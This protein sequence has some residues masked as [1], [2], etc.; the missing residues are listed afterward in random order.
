MSLLIG[1]VITATDPVL[2]ATI[3]VGPL[4]ERCIPARLR[5]TLSAESG[6]ND[7][8]AMMLVMV[9]VYLTTLPSHQVASAWFRHTLLWQILVAIGIGAVIGLVAGLGVRW[10]RR[11]AYQGELSLLTV[12]LSLTFTTLILT[13][14]VGGDGI[15]GTFVAAAVFNRFLPKDNVLEEHRLQ[16]ALGRIFD[17][18]MF[19]LFGLALPWDAWA[20]LGWRTYLFAG[21]VMFLRRVPVWLLLS[22]V[23]PSLRRGRDALF[24]G[25]F[26]P[27]GISALFYATFASERTQNLA[28]WPVTSLVVFASTMVYG[29]TGTPLSKWI[30]PQLD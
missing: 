25:W 15:L 5:N 7:G 20:A 16:E 24:N 4:A 26:G 30:G 27:I 12:S 22:P 10:I 1:T 23:L 11:G 9:P 2:A 6:A 14:G 28:L 29:I 3:L 18:P 8:L 21:V 19:F 17:L 13:R